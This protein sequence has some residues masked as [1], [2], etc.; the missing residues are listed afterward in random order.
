[1]VL[2]FLGAWSFGTLRLAPLDA[3]SIPEERHLRVALVQPNI[4]Q[5]EKWDK[6]F[7]QRNLEVHFDL[8]LSLGRDI[9]LLVWPETAA[10]FFYHKHPEFLVGMRRLT[11][12][13]ETT[14]A[15]GAPLVR[16]RLTGG[17]NYYNALLF[18]RPEKALPSASYLKHHLVPFG[19]FIPFRNWVPSIFNKFTHGTSDFSRGPGPV[20]MPFAKG[21]LG[22][23]I[24]Y[25]AIFP[26]EVATLAEQG[27]K[28][29]LNVT[30]D[31][32]FGESAKPQHLA[33]TRMRAIENRL[34]LIR[35][36]NTGISA[37]FDQAGRELVR[38]KANKRA[39]KVIKVPPGQGETLFQKS[40]HFWVMI[41]V[42]LVA[43]ALTM[44]GAL[45]RGWRSAFVPHKKR[46]K[47]G[48]S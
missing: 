11:A 44:S 35:S 6:R 47:T 28:W 38:I 22:P 15:V 7:R 12:I 23:L 10:S 34:P 31:A 43:M 2:P 16:R 9:D 29:L 41:Q 30:N 5:H 48:S 8:S 45:G 18:F 14:A 17:H 39:V 36:A 3:Q 20:A 42:L 46:K 21:A 37:I 26:G 27:A 4:P 33:M 19:E 1:M 25:E 40:R 13:L 24:C 32:W